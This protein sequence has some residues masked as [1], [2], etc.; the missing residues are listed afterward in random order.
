MC[1]RYLQNL[2]EIEIYGYF[3]GHP[4]FG[5]CIPFPG[6]TEPN[7]I[8]DPAQ[9][10]QSKVTFEFRDSSGGLPTRNQRAKFT[11]LRLYSICFHALSL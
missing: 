10:F 3:D 8:I 2:I 7:R 1:R 5:G 9:L 6:R 11:Q 4:V